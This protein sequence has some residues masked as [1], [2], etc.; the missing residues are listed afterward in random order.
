[1]DCLL[2]EILDISTVNDAKP[3]YIAWLESSSPLQ[4][5]A[6]NVS[7]IDA[8][9]LQLL[10]SL[11]T[12]ARHQKIDIQLINATEKLQEAVSILGLQTLF[13]SCSETGED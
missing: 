3:Q 6:T 11:F 5:D 10:A 13:D 2:P 9:G 1:M 8:A 4:V 12:S 7:R